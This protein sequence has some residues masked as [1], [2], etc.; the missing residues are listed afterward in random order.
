MDIKQINRLCLAFQAKLK[1]ALLRVGIARL[2]ILGLALLPLFLF[3]DWWVHFR[4]VWRLANLLIYLGLL[5]ATAWWTLVKPLS[6]HWAK[7]ETLNYIDSVMPAEQAML[8]DL[9]ELMEGQDIQETQTPV[10]KDLADNSIQGIAPIAEQARKAETIEKNRVRQWTKW[11][12]MT[13]LAFVLLC[14]PL[15]RHA[16]IGLIR[17]F[18]PFTSLRWPHRTTIVVEEPERGW[19]IPA[20]ESLPVQGLVSGV[21]PPQITLA[22]RDDTSGHWIRENIPVGDDDTFR[23]VFQE[24]REPVRFYIRGGDYVT[25]T[26]QV[27]IIQRPYI[28]GIT[29]HYEY[30]VYAGIPNRSLPSGQLNG[31]EGTRVR[32]E[33]ESSMELQKALFIFEEDDPVEM[34]RHRDGE[35]FEHQLFLEREGA[36]RVEL[37]EK[38]GYR[39]VRPE[40]YDIRVIPDMRP[41]V[42]ILSPGRNVSATRRASVDIAFRASDDYGLEQVQFLYQAEGDDEP[43]ELDNTITGPIPQRGQ[44]SEARFTWDLNQTEQIPESGIIRYFVRAKDVNPTGKGITESQAFEI[45]LIRPSE[46]HLE[47]I[48]RA[49]AIE[50]EARIA[51]ENQLQAWRIGA[52]WAAKGTGDENDPLWT[53]MTDKQNSS[54]RAARAMSMHLRDLTASYE[55]NDMHREFMSARLNDIIANLQRVTD[56]FHR[57]IDSKMREARPRTADEALPAPLKT[58]RSQ[59]YGEFKD[60]QKYAVLHLERALKKLF[61][62]LDLQ[63]TSVRTTML[64]EEQDEILKLTEAIAPRFIGVEIQDLA[65]SDVDLLLTLGSRQKTMFDVETELEKQL[66]FMKA[67]AELQR[68]TSIQEPLDIAYKML[69]DHRVN[70][71]LDR[72]AKAIA[73]SQPYQIIKDQQAALHI[74]DI[75]RGGLILAGQRVDEDPK[76]TLAMAPVETLGDVV[77]VEKKTPEEEDLLVASA[78]DDEPA[79]RMTPQEMLAALPIGSDKLSMALDLAWTIQDSVLART[80]YLH[81]NSSEKEMPRYVSLKQFILA[82]FQTDAIE[83]ADLAIKEADAPEDKPVRDTIAEV[84][85]EFEQSL[86]LIRERLIANHTQHIQSDSMSTLRDSMNFV[87]LRKVVSEAVEENKRRDGKDAFDRK[88]V[89]RNEDLDTV[90]DMVNDI[91][92]ATLVQNDVLRKAR[93]LAEFKDAQ[94]TLADLEKINRARTEKNYEKAAGLMKGVVKKSETLTP[95]IKARIDESGVGALAGFQGVSLAALEKD[96]DAAIAAN[97]NAVSL[98]ARTFQNIRNLLGERERSEVELAAE[99]PIVH[100]EVSQEEWERRQSA[101]FLLEQLKKDTRLP[102]EVRAIMIRALSQELPEKYKALISAYYASFLQQ[103]GMQ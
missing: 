88:F 70:D 32:L 19:T 74:L 41:E 68:R 31:L 83:M 95:D 2:V 6:R 33:I 1:A 93:R 59:A 54:I 75:V 21:K 72:A 100:E 97:E 9:Y 44:Q 78:A 18:N 46:F 49:R 80:K 45:N 89:V 73:N 87:S 25:D 35:K 37:Y 27:E 5:G 36:Y 43:R 96:A 65:D 79:E 71:H 66:V 38:H 48:E 98:L 14:L 103:E 55:Q 42:E 94:G 81:E 92:Y 56:D 69:R 39:E 7:K 85:T 16:A 13:A 8:L 53:D 15:P 67:N 60:P 84:K 20:L 28:R 62:W 22:Y 99:K 57:V 76:I 30:P 50:A 90:A 24:V 23:Y 11:M 58:K 102:E 51:W 52:Q 63:I 3:L 26:Y 34:T 40:V 12:G 4:T 10:G 86:K 101:E 64:H 82:D 17:F 29:A 61:D 91:N 77:R 47:S